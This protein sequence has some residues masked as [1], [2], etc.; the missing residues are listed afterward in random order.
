MHSEESIEYQ[1]E[2]VRPSIRKAITLIV[3]CLFSLRFFEVESDLTSIVPFDTFAFRIFIFV[4]CSSFLLISFSSVKMY[5]SRVDGILGSSFLFLALV[6]LQTFFTS[7]PDIE[8]V[9]NVALSVTI[10]ALIRLNVVDKSL[11]LQCLK[12][13]VI[14]VGI[15]ELAGCHP[16]AGKIIRSTVNPARQGLFYASCIPIIC[17]TLRYEINNK[18]GFN[19]YFSIFI[20]LLSLTIC[21]YFVF[22][23][24]SKT[25]LLALV[26]SMCFLASQYYKEQLHNLNLPQGNFLLGGFILL[27]IASTIYFIYCLIDY[28]FQ[29]L[30]GRFLIWTISLQMIPEHL[31]VG[32]G[33]GNFKNVYNLE[34][35]R[36]FTDTHINS[37]Y[38]LADDVFY[39]FNEYIQLLVETGL[40]GIIIICL[41]MYCLIKAYR[42]KDLLSIGAMSFLLFIFITCLSSYPL[43]SLS[44][45]FVLIVTIAVISSEQTLFRVKLSTFRVAMSVWLLLVTFLFRSDIDR[46][47]C[48]IFWKGASQ[49]AMTGNFSTAK[50]YYQKAYKE[51]NS[52][53]NFL[54]NFGAETFIS[55]NTKE[56]I[57]L[58]ESASKKISHSNLYIYLG[59]AH[60]SENEIEKAR[61]CYLTAAN[62]V[63]HKFL[64]KYLLFILEVRQGNTKNAL[65]MAKLISDFPVKIPSRDIIKWKADAAMYLNTGSINL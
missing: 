34:Q 49:T 25:T 59:N 65:K 14:A 2:L 56:S 55:G 30:R 52:N 15:F 35:S 62:M 24:Q 16:L 4:A 39:C 48:Y 7:N 63:P 50:P 11:L 33:L 38:L 21:T 22:L 6:L 43:R 58:L 9:E 41:F 28:D 37:D 44:T 13:W 20:A 18:T 57:Q 36:Y 8:L 10:L 5:M 64:P 31:F 46:L 61:Q 40:T 26:I 60:L 45:I 29:S 27:S 23:S 47:R 3:S 51:L 17:S 1:M 12:F 32:I 53:G 42:P 19:K 54:F